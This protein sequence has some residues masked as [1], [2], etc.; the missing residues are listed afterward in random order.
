MAAFANVELLKDGNYEGKPYKEGAPLRVPSDVAARWVKLKTAKAY[1]GD[2][3]P[4]NVKEK[5]AKKK[6]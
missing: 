4:E 5:S 3:T 2:K 1:K 6:S